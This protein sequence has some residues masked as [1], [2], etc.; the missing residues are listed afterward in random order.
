M[1]RPETAQYENAEQ[2]FGVRNLRFADKTVQSTAATAELMLRKMPV[3]SAVLNDIIHPAITGYPGGSFI[4]QKSQTLNQLKL[5]PVMLLAGQVI[6]D[7]GAF[8]KVAVGG[9]N[10]RAAIYSNTNIETNWYPNALLV[11]TGNLSAAGVGCTH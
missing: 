4:G 2:D 8:V 11:D 10:L 6:Q 5:L 9:E 7:L 1:S 3:G